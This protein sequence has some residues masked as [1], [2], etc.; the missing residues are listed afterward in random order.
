MLPPKQPEVPLLVEPT[1]IDPNCATEGN[2]LPPLLGETYRAWK[3]GI[4]CQ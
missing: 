4:L 2:C 3:G 1:L